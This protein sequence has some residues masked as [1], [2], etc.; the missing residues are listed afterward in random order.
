MGEAEVLIGKIEAKVEELI[1]KNKDLEA[2]SALLEEKNALLGEENAV[3]KKEKEDLEDRDITIKLTKAIE[4]KEDIDELRARIN[5]LLQKVNKSLAL[6]VAIQN[7]DIDYG[8]GDDLYKCGVGSEN[9][10]G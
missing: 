9:V 1:L 4:Q 8:R 7:K 5:E 2:K 3:L 10:Q 6:L